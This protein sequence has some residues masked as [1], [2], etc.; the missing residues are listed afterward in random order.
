[1]YKLLNY[2]SEISSKKLFVFTLV[3]VFPL[4]VL[5]VLLFVLIILQY[6]FFSKI[7]FLFEIVL[8]LVSYFSIK[9]IKEEK[10]VLWAIAIFVVFIL[11]VM[12][13]FALGAFGS[14]GDGVTVNR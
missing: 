2:I 9:F 10:Y 12:I 1:M 8:V 13:Y 14:I 11:Y 7:L 4:I 3:L 5:S 6:I